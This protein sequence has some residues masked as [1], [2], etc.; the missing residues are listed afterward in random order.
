[1]EETPTLTP[2]ERFYN[3][4][5]VRVAEYQKATPELQRAKCKAYNERIKAERPERYQEVLAQKRKYYTEITKPK[6]E[7]AKRRKL[8]KEEQRT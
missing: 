4:H 2:A 8:E 1:M 6:K 5:K 3:K 7:E